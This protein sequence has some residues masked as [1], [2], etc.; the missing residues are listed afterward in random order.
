MPPRCSLPPAIT[1]TWLNGG[2]R[3]SL[4]LHM[5]LY[6]FSLG[7]TMSVKTKPFI[8]YA[9]YSCALLPPLFYTRFAIT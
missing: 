6:T 2:L 9:F 5:V 8:G 4:A 7:S 1:L 3:I